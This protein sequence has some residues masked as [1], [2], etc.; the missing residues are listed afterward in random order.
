MGP[1]IASKAFFSGA[2]QNNLTNVQYVYLAVACAGAAVGALFLFSKLPE[3][4]ETSARRNSIVQD[5]TLEA[6]VDQYGNVIGDKPIYKQFNMIFGFIAQ[7][8]AS[9][10]LPSTRLDTDISK[11]FA[12]WAH[13]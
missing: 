3:V 9:P 5:S 2:N 13:K 8:S 6:C 4:E 12:M 10:S 11:S 7:V 1:L